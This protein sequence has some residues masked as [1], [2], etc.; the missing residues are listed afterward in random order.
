MKIMRYD[1][2][3]TGMARRKTLTIVSVGTGVTSYHYF[4]KQ[5]T[6]FYKITYTLITGAYNPTPRY[7]PKRNEFTYPHKDL[8]KNVQSGFIH[9][10]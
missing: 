2:M 1:N 9:N 10:T 5:S 7:L 8:Y 4:R 3:P 6:I